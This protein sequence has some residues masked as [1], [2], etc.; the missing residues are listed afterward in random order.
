MPKSWATPLSQ[1]AYALTT[2]IDDKGHRQIVV[3][4]R[5]ILTF[6]V[7]EKRFTPSPIVA[8]PV[9]G[10]NQMKLSARNQLKGTVISV[11]KGP[12][13]AKVKIDIG[14]GNVIT[15][16][17]TAETVDDLG[18]AS[19]DAVVAIVKSSEVIIGK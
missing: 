16:V 15:S 11:D 18:L 6:G 7:I 13:S 1:K 8:T 12:V 10:D 5:L 4:I 9:N 17:V 19:G 14:G 2:F 3:Y